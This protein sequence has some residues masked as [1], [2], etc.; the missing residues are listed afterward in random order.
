M[1][2][3][4]QAASRYVLPSLKSVTKVLE[5]SIALP[6]NA[7]LRRYAVESLHMKQP[8]VLDPLR[9]QVSGMLAMA[10]AMNR[11]PGDYYSRTAK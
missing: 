11:V 6:A 1:S 8:L 7:P 3:L 2:F 4:R 10:L 5:R 9:P